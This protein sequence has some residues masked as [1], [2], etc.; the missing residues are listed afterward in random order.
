MSDIIQREEEKRMPKLV[1]KNDELL[2]SR[3]KV[4]LAKVTRSLPCI[5][6]SNMPDKEVLERILRQYSSAWKKLAKL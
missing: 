3:K 6:N 4:K 2:S 1:I 5:E